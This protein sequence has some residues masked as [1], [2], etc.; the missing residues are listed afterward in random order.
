MDGCYW[1]VVC[2]T[3]HKGMLMSWTIPDDLQQHSAPVHTGIQWS[4]CF[5]LMFILSTG[6]LG[7]QQLLDRGKFRARL[8]SQRRSDI[9]FTIKTFRLLKLIFL[10]QNFYV[11]SFSHSYRLTVHDG[12]SDPLG[13]NGG[14]VITASTPG[15]IP[16]PR[17]QLHSQGSFPGP[18]S[19]VWEWD[20]VYLNGR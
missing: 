7:Y 20:W 10:R 17:S 13:W 4:M 12:Y 2:I 16:R 1:K 6:C 15:F 18:S 8:V 19:E 9:P 3:G 11:H 14:W 5:Y